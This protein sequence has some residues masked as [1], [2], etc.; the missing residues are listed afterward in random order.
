MNIWR[1]AMA[2]VERRERRGKN[3]QVVRSYRVRWRGPDGKERNKSF[4]RKVD[5][6]RFAA[7]VSADLVRGQYVDP[8][9]GKI[10][11]ET[12]A[13]KWLAAQTFDEGTHVAVEL[14]FRLHAYPV[15][16]NRNL[17]DIQPS[18][19][20][21][22]LRTLTDLAPSYRQIIF[23]N[24]STVF[25]AAVDDALIVAN[26]CRAR[27]VRRPK[28]GHHKVVP[29]TRDRVLAVRDEL[30]AR[31]QLMVW[32]GAGLGMRQ[33]EIFG[34][35]PEDIDIDR[36]EV[37]VRRQVKLVGNKQMFGLPKGRKVRDVPL[38]DA[39]LEAINAHM[40]AYPPIEVTLPWDRT[41]GKPA[42]FSL[43][44]YSREKKALG[45]NYINTFIWKPAL[46][47]AGVPVTREN[48]SHALR[49]FYAS[50]ALHEGESIKALSEYLGHADP[51]FT[52]R[53][54]T[55]LVEDSAERTKRAVD[56]VF[57]HQTPEPEPGD[58]EPD[59]KLVEDV[60]PDEDDDDA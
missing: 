10:L 14:R 23:A 39:V 34:L 54:Y 20:Q 37:H 56:A 40:T 41:D 6:D 57:G 19:I 50:T 2:H 13:R 46:K 47:R 21:G 51:G 53:T 30:P 38:P 9:A 35:S 33:G 43:L 42:T 1:I 16:G 17:N 12:Y 11:F 44:L 36:G 58:G 48:G 4:R 8:D 7:T 3:G 31:Y 55:H 32:L 26:P 49:H 24:V 52:L 25:T 18:T 29:W 45:R 28:R 22:W 60:E 27:S 59:E 5:A 15:L